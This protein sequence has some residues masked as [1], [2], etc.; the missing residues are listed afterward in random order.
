METAVAER[1]SEEA[2]PVILSLERMH[3]LNIERPVFWRSIALSS[4][5]YRMDA[6][7]EHRE[8]GAREIYTKG[9]YVAI[10]LIELIHIL[11]YVERHEQGKG[12]K[13]YQSSTNG[14]TCLGDTRLLANEIL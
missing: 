9:I 3:I 10:L 14:E 11:I 8:A 13:V 2:Y 1:Y 5:P 12:I 7:P 6:H 4:H